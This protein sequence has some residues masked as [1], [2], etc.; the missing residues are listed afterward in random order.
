MGRD[1]PVNI[2]GAIAAIL[3]EIDFPASLANAVFMVARI[4]GILA[5]AH[6]EMEEM[7]PMRR[8]DP[9]DYSYAGPAHRTLPQSDQGAVQ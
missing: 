6:E 5:H 4:A 8:I 2:D 1:L 3:C 9:V 7:P